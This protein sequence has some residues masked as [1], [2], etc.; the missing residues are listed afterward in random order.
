MSLTFS[1]FS[2]PFLF[3]CFLF[4]LV[5]LY[6]LNI[7]RSSGSMKPFAWSWFDAESFRVDA[8]IQ[9][10]TR[11]FEQKLHSPVLFLKYIQIIWKVIFPLL[12]W[13]LAALPKSDYSFSS[14]LISDWSLQG[15]IFPRY[16][17]IGRSNRPASRRGLAGYL[18]GMFNP[19]AP[20]H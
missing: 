20:P 18:A 16:P 17:L 10:E 7:W 4:L 11:F 19:S 1:C 15:E 12:F 9:M 3:F 6:L 2:F 14:V 13:L 5:I 8:L